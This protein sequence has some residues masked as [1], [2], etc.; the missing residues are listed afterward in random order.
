[1]RRLA[2]FLL[3]LTLIGLATFCAQL[4]KDNLEFFPVRLPTLLPYMAF[5]ICAG[6]FALVL[7]GVNKTIWRFTSVGDYF[8]IVL[9]TIVTVAGAEL[10]GFAYNRLDGIARSLPIMQAMLI[11]VFLIAARILAR[12]R[13]GRRAKTLQPFQKGASAE[14]ETILI[15]GINRLSELYLRSVAEYAAERIHIAGLLERKERLVGQSVQQFPVLGT[16]EQLLEIIRNLEV[17]GVFTSRVLVTTRFDHLSDAAKAVLHEVENS[18]RIV[19]D[20]LTERLGLDDRPSRSQSG[21]IPASN[22]NA[23][24][25]LSDTQLTA[26]KSRPYWRVKRMADASVAFVLLCLT[27]PLLFVVAL[28]VAVDVGFPVSFWQQRPGLGGRPFKL[29]KFRT[30]AAAHDS[31]GRRLSD[32]ERV[33]IIGRLLRRTRLDELPQLIN[34]LTGKMSFIGPRPLLPAD[35][36]SEYAARLIV[37]PGLTGWAQVGG[38]RE[39]K[40]ADKAAL[41]VWY[42]L[43]ASFLLDLHILLRTIHMMIAGERPNAHAIETAWTDLG[44]AG[45]CTPGLIA[46]LRSASHQSFRPGE[47]QAA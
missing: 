34:I 25:S 39:V 44:N 32:E 35:Q 5:S 20:F 22:I 8:R 43:N 42:V 2:A 13:F 23:A 24:F 30:M 40:P 26:L 47:T 41:D 3:D 46:R 6:A 10:C 29:Y 21:D 31:H 4:L 1:M 28:L 33:S 45:V 19:V 38:G 15:I 27:A 7:F 36:P 37:R 9:A 16:P 12:I 17:H 14:A 11:A 18:N